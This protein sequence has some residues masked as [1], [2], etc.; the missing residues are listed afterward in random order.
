MSLSHTDTL[1]VHEVAKA[2]LMHGAY[3]IC[4]SR[5]GNVVETSGNDDTTKPG[6]DSIANYD[7]NSDWTIYFQQNLP[8]H[9]SSTMHTL[10]MNDIRRRRLSYLVPADTPNDISTQSSDTAILHLAYAK[11]EHPWNTMHDEYHRFL[12]LFSEAPASTENNDPNSKAN[13]KNSSMSLFKF[14][15]SSTSMLNSFM[16]LDIIKERAGNN[17][18]DMIVMLKDVTYLEDLIPDI[19]EICEMLSTALVTQMISNDIDASEAANVTCTHTHGSNSLGQSIIDLHRHWFH[20]T[21]KGVLHA[22]TS[23]DDRT[24][25]TELAFNFVQAIHTVDSQQQRQPS[26]TINLELFRSCITT[27]LDMFSD[28]M[29]R[30][31]YAHS[32]PKMKEIGTTLWKWS[33]SVPMT[34]PGKVSKQHMIYHYCPTGQWMCQYITHR[35]MTNTELTELLSQA[36][37]DTTA[38]TNTLSELYGVATKCLNNINSSVVSNDDFGTFIWIL[39]LFRSVLL[40]TRV[41]YFPWNLI[42]PTTVASSEEDG[43]DTIDLSK[44]ETIQRIFHLFYQLLVLLLNDSQSGIVA[45]SSMNIETI[46]NIC[47]DSVE[48]LICGTQR[49]KLSSIQ[50]RMITDMETMI[51]INTKDSINYNEHSDA[52]C[53]RT[54]IQNMIKRL[55]DNG[56][57]IK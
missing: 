13:Q 6:L 27:L 37:L 25:Q 38:A 26:A 41:S 16:T 55:C 22:A 18:S 32:D 12:E 39:S 21:R 31:T 33:T 5:R 29:D 34:S 7:S 15:P 35:Y 4:Q 11:V 52:T 42:F 43:N 8:Y 14:A 19:A 1:L 36:S 44:N 53:V 23:H 20:R 10:I 54:M 46:A 28:W 45:L 24:M 9:I 40:A 30:N 17:L 50:S 51:C 56:I 3:N 57:I 48:I 49:K 47:V 2:V